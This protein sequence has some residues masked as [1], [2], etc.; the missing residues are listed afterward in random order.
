MCSTGHYRRDA[1]CRLSPPADHQ[2]RVAI[3]RNPGRTTEAGYPFLIFGC[4]K[5][6]LSKRGTAGDNSWQADGVRCTTQA[7]A[8]SALN[9]RLILSQLIL[10]TTS[11]ESFPGQLSIQQCLSSDQS[12]RGTMS[13][14]GRNCCFNASKLQEHQLNTAG[15]ASLSCEGAPKCGPTTY[16]ALRILRDSPRAAACLPAVISGASSL[17]CDLGLFHG[18]E[19]P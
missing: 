5:E 18:W 8:A 2:S 13:A 14:A 15:H 4:T 3:V 12:T 16:P 6:K 17:I 10:S 1:Q 9:R 7:N 19:C 11:S